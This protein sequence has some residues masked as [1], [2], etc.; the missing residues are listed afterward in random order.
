M[1]KEIEGAQN[2]GTGAVAAPATSAQTG[3]SRD[4][5]AA[6]LS[7]K[8]NPAM[9]VNG[10][11][12]GHATDEKNPTVGPGENGSTLAVQELE[13]QFLANVDPYFLAN[14]I[15]SL[16]GGEGIGLEEGYLQ[17]SWQPHGI[18]FRVGKMKESFGR[19]NSL[20]T[21]ALPFVEKSL[22]GNAVFGE[23]G[24]S[25]PGVEASWLAPLPWYGL[26]TA[27]AMN[28]NNDVAFKSPR[29][30][31]IAGMAAFKNVFDLTDDATLEAQASY[32]AG[33]NVYGRLSQIYGGHLVFKWRPARKA[34]TRSLVATIEGI[35]AHQSLVPVT[36][37]GPI[38]SNVGGAYGYAQWKLAAR[39]FTAAR[40]DYLGF[41]ARE[42]GI[43]RRES[44]LLAFVP[45]EFSSLRL[46][47]SAN[48]PAFGEK[49]I[50]E[51][52]LQL[53]FTLG[54]HPAHSY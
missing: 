49:Q 19:E 38:S 1:L 16:P 35:Y 23:E 42:A 20:H 15:L 50:F 7:N 44:L 2:A 52:F 30:R 40:F 29:D 48:Q 24:L 28:G 21:H 14:L 11:F 26:L 27:V 25:E 32:A 5:S 17:P 31:D 22:I 36:P 47:G 4:S 51:G 3:S 37:G 9:S 41:N 10:L 39:W 6:W 45:T 8:Y 46:E 53:N 34:A 43:T 18:V 33:D 12:L 13:V 54:A